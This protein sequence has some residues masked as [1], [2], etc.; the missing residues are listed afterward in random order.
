[1]GG[2]KKGRGVDWKGALLNKKALRHHGQGGMFAGRGGERRGNTTNSTWQRKKKNVGK[3]KRKRHEK[4]VGDGT[5]HKKTRQP[6]TKIRGSIS[7][8]TDCK[9]QEV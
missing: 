7:T 1:M 9:I 5:S 4:K 2:G 6:R 3:K 8:R